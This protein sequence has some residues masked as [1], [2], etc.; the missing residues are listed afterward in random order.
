LYRPLAEVLI[1]TG[2][3][4]SEALALNWGDVELDAGRIRV[5]RSIKDGGVIGSTKGDRGRAVDIGPRIQL[6]LRDLA[7]YQGL[8]FR[9]RPETRVFANR[10]GVVPERGSVSQG[11]HKRALRNAGLRPSIRLH[12]LRHTAAT[13]WLSAG[14]P[15]IYVQRQ[16]GH[17]SLTTTEQIYAHL[18][19]GMF[20]GAPATVEEK[21]W[22]RVKPHAA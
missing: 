5:M 22:N 19:E 21:I 13:T 4:I 15:L 10:R 9:V 7:E 12:D 20:A 2:M 6:V 17:A 16:L 3:R 18:E 14:L 8:W 1:A 11:F